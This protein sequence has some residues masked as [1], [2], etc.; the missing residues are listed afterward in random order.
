[1]KNQNNHSRIKA[2]LTLGLL[3][4]TLGEILTGASPPLYFFKPIFFLF[5]LGMYGS[6]VLLI[7][8]F[9]RSHHLGWVNVILLGLAYGMIEEGLII[10]SFYNLQW[11]G[12]KPLGTY[13]Y[14]LGINWVW[15]VFSS[16]T[17]AFLTVFSSIVLAESLFPRLASREWLTHKQRWFAGLFF[18]GAFM[19]GHN[20][21]TN[22][23][24]PGYRP[25]FLSYLLIVALTGIIIKIGFTFKRIDF[26]KNPSVS[27]HF[28]YFI[29]GLIVSLAL[30][31]IPY[32][33]VKI[34]VPVLVTILL[35]N[36][37]IFFGGY[38]ILTWIKNFGGWLGTE[39]LALT[40][41]IMTPW[42][43]RMS[44]LELGIM[45]GVREMNMFGMTMAAVM[46]V[47]LLEKG[48]RNLR[49][50]KL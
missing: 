4:P 7:R 37:I 9:V 10:T 50:V 38:F 29:V 30:I 14:F 41:G 36:G 20:L 2:V 26:E 28:H 6:G 18:L 45:T 3:A 48:F 12:V 25:P 13:G 47:I 44:F 33:S 35:M 34:G 8:D 24:Y 49:R 42:L 11:G 39:R 46:I 17:H 40:S 23:L 15:V 19:F 16:F 27:H 21:F 32:A 5:L 22:V 31:I 43:I 1:M